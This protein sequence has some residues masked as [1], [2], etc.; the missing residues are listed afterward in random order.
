MHNVD[1]KPNLSRTPVV[2]S[3]MESRSPHLPSERVIDGFTLP[4]NVTMRNLRNVADTISL[5]ELGVRIPHCRYPERFEEGFRYGLAHNGRTEVRTQFGPL[6]SKGFCWAKVFYRKFQPGHRHAASG[7]GTGK[8]TF[9][10]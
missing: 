2:L 1:T 9:A 6:Y 4:P 7:S 8:I 10:E 3:G 5:V